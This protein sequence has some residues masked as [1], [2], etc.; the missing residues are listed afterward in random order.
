MNLFASTTC[1]IERPTRLCS[2]TA[3]VLEPG[4]EYVAT[5]V[6]LETPQ[7]SQEVDDVDDHGKN[8]SS[9]P[10]R[11]TLASAGGQ[12]NSRV[13]LLGDLRLKRVDVCLE[14]W[15]QG[16][17]PDR[18]FS[19]WKAHV[20]QPAEKKKLF[21]D[22]EVLMNLFIRLAD[23][24]EPRRQAFRFVLALI[25]MRKKLL[26]YERS[27]SQSH[28]AGELQ[29]WIMSIKPSAVPAGVVMETH[30]QGKTSSDADPQ[31][32]QAPLEPQEQ[33]VLNPQLD[34]QQI[35]EVTEQLGEVLETQF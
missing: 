12:D 16:Q 30:D 31:Q 4:Q 35:R 21:V 14:A 11:S 8:E 20:P 15:E 27:E 33:R 24:D 5:L 28:Q 10:Q 18:L 34:E 25:L 6:E 32:A 22:D 29:W 23:T 26:R 2:V 3:K 13:S 1:D 7:E 19:Y 9:V 17:R